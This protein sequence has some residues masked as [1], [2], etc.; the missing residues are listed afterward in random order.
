[1]PEEKRKQ[2]LE[3]LR[4]LGNRELA[5]E[6]TRAR[7]RL[8]QLKR[9]HITRQLENTA[10]IPQTKDYIARILTIMKEREKAAKGGRKE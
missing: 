10:A 6:L 3:R 9:E 7:E 1:V 4:N 5:E 8:F 2:M